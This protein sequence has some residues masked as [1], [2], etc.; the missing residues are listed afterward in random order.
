MYSASGENV[1]NASRPESRIEDANST[2]RTAS[3]PEQVVEIDPQAKFWV[4]PLF[5]EVLKRVDGCPPDQSVYT[6]REVSLL[7]TQYIRE[8]RTKFFPNPHDVSTAQVDGDLL[9]LAFGVKVLVTQSQGANP[10]IRD[11]FPLK[12]INLST[13]FESKLKF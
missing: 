12:L 6:Y 8:N 1:A 10:P 11:N 4:R 13:N 2:R 7:L 5:H 9:G 3:N